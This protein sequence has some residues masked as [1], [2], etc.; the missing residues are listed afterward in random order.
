MHP[1]LCI[2]RKSIQILPTQQPKRILIHKPPGIR[3][4][5]PEEVVM[6]PRLTVS[7]LVL[8]V[9]G[10]VCAIR[11]LGFLF[12]TTL[13]G[14]FSVPQQIPVLIGHLSRDT[15]LVAVE[16]VGLLVAFSVFDDVV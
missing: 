10:S 11:N 3:L 13:A 14:V 16:V 7:V 6:Q 8:L 4:I 12:Q 15:D 1:R 5:I 9:E 2:R